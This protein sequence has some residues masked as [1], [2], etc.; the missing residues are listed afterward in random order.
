M[1]NNKTLFESKHPLPSFE[2]L[3]E[4]FSY[5]PETGNL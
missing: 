1:D 4:K 5:D 3:S 2:Q